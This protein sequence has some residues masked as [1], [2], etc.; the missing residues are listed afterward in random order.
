MSNNDI[1]D[2]KLYW[3]KKTRIKNRNN[4]TLISLGPKKTSPKMAAWNRKPIPWNK[5]NKKDNT[6]SLLTVFW[7]SII[8]KFKI[9]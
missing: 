6:S 3:N 1:F 8:I 5:Y 7:I 9:I 4:M 2:F